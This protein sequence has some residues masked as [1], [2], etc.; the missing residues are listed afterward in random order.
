MSGRVDPQIV[1]QAY[2]ESGESIAA[3]AAQFGISERTIYRWM[4]A[5][6]EGDWVALRKARGIVKPKLQVISN[7]TPHTLLPPPARPRRSGDINELE[8]VDLAISDLSTKIAGDIDARSLGGCAG[9]LCRLI[10]LRR[11]LVPPTAAA[12]AEQVIALGIS[13]S[14][15]VAELKKRWA[16]GA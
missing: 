12:L 7:A 14:E 9:A 11:K 8:I 5:D 2:L 6:P 10:E 15:F 16:Q 4:E 13:P 3:I 1:K